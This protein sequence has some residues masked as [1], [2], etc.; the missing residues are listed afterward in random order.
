MATMRLPG[1]PRRTEGA[2]LVAVLIASMLVGVVLASQAITASRQRRAVSEAV[3][4]QY[5]QL[6]GWEFSRQAQRDVEDSL[7]HTLATYAHPERTHAP[8]RGD[9]NCQVLE[10]VEHY[11]QVPNGGN[12]TV[13]S[14][15]NR[16]PDHSATATLTQLLRN[17][18]TLDGISGES[19]VRLLA[20]PGRPDR[21]IAVRHEPHLQPAGGFVGLVAG[22]ASLVPVLRR[23]LERAPLVPAVIL[24]SR[25]VRT[26]VDLHVSDAQG[27]RLVGTGSTTPGPFASDTPVLAG[28]PIPLTVRTA[29]SARFVA[30]LGP[31]FGPSA[32][33][34]LVLALVSLNALLLGIAIWQLS[35]E[36]ALSRMRSNFVAGVSH[37]LRTPLAQIQMFSE[38]LL[39]GRVRN[40]EERNRA[41]TI[42][43][44]ESVRLSHMAANVLRFH[45]PQGMHTAPVHVDLGTLAVDVVEAFAPVAA[46]KSAKVN[47]Q[48]PATPIS[49]QGDAGALRQVLLN[50]LDNAVKFGPEGQTILVVVEERDDSAL[51]SV[52][53]EGPGV[54]P[55]ERLRIFSAFV[56]GQDTRGTGGAGIG[57]AVV[58]QA[59]A[60]HGGV[61]S[62]I[63][64]SNGGARFVVSLPL[65][66]VPQPATA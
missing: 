35:R 5:A 30:D 19:M 66:R 20:F 49:I 64:G 13:T 41:L 48:T 33:T 54:P 23:T 15:G 27:T 16:I 45:R 25:D 47:V 46:A 63:D 7:N 2:I 32:S 58:S 37:E 65:S 34:V 14:E 21:F 61:V 60:A 62:V 38:M 3:L 57:L 22:T 50:L 53:D 6:A 51:V 31:A 11:I 29:M 40:R 4:R 39:L 12:V 28:F 10:G 44:Q 55:A 9:C 56:R 17:G 1:T 26:L 36:R 43:R 8:S 59:V 52:E 24:G 18:Q 42:I